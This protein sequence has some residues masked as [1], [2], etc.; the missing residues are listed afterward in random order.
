ME[1]QWNLIS[2]MRA[3]RFGPRPNWV[4]YG[5]EPSRLQ[6]ILEPQ[7]RCAAIFM[8]V[9]CGTE[10]GEDLLSIDAYV[11]LTHPPSFAVSIDNKPARLLQ[12]KE[13]ERHKVNSPIFPYTGSSSTGLG[14]TRRH[15]IR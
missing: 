10:F 4:G 13:A 2:S 8:A 1:R 9:F 15:G 3:S 6:Q 14:Q 12:T 5:H 11:A 7:W